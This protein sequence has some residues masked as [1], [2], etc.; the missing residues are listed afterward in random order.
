M[1]PAT[2]SEQDK[3]GPPNLP[4]QA[5]IPFDYISAPAQ[6]LYVISFGALLQVWI[7]S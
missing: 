7:F 5:R 4:P 3:P 1:V 2:K 6:R